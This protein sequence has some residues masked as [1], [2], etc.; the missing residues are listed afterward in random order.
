MKGKNMAFEHD[1]NNRVPRLRETLGIEEGDSDS[2][3]A[4][5]LELV[6]RRILSYIHAAQMPEGLEFALL[7]IAA[8]YWRQAKPGSDETPVGAVTAVKRG[9]VQTNF[10]SAA[11]AVFDT[12]GGDGFFGWRSVLN[13]YRRL[14]W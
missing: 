4:F 1:K 8:S 5:V 9:D 6:E 14:S 12:E 11:N 13:D 2:L 10:A 3:L 7:A